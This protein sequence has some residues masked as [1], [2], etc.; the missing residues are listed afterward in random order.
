MSAREEILEKPPRSTPPDESSA[1]SAATS[2]RRPTAAARSCARQA[3]PRPRHEASADGR[4]GQ[5]LAVPRRHRLRPQTPAVAALC[6]TR[7]RRSTSPTP[8]RGRSRPATA[9]SRATPP[10]GRD[11]GQLIVA[12]E[13]ITGG[14]ERHRLEPMARPRRPAR[15][16]I[17]ERPEVA[18]ADAGY[19]NDR[20]STRSKLAESPST[21]RRRR[22]PKAPAKI[23]S[24]PTTTD[25]T[26]AQ[27][28]DAE[29]A[30]RRRQQMIEP[31]FAR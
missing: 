10:G 8:T 19:W 1:T 13:V 2:C 25:A 30:Y 26:P 20:R 3:P 14:N 11:R 28:A 29:A 16:G 31:V 18:L 22:Q 12:A 15:A 5:A 27:R 24:G 9:S 23:R 6:P 7:Q 4:F 21:A 17:D